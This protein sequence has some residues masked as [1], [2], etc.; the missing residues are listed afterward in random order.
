MILL[1]S[2]LLLMAGCGNKSD[3][4]SFVVDSKGNPIT[5]TYDEIPESGNGMGF[6]VMEG[7]DKFRPIT[8]VLDGYE[9]TTGENDPAR[10]LW[11]ADAEDF[12][13]KDII[14]IVN[15]KNKLVM[16]YDEDED[17]PSVFTLEKYKYE[18]YT[19]GVRFFVG[20]DK[21]TIYMNAGLVCDGSD[22]KNVTDSLGLTDSYEVD[23]FN[24]KKEMPAS[25]IDGATGFLIGA[26]KDKYYDFSVYKGTMLHHATIKADTM[27]F[28][29][30]EVITLQSPVEKTDKGYFIINLPDNLSPGYYYVCG[31]GMFKYEK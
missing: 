27:L 29:S 12:D 5:M 2:C 1:V 25:N 24:G 21:S 30:E 10:C 16:V 6:Y 22:A 17:I 9:G 19:L 26:E 13:L 20:D 11:W 4:K 28:T 14:P 18:G 7:K 8:S 23:E 3:S 15:S 31:L